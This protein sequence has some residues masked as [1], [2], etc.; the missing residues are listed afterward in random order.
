MKELKEF[1]KNNDLKFTPGRRNSD[2]VVI[3]GYALSID[4][5]LDDIKNSIEFDLLDIELIDELEKVHIYAKSNN[6][7]LFWNTNLAKNQYEF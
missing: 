7:G 3:C 6:Y 1:I 5:T 2:C 4:A